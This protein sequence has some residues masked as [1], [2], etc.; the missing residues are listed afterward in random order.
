MTTQPKPLVS[1]RA[2]EAAAQIYANFRDHDFANWIRQGTNAGGDSNWAIQMMARFEAETLAS[3]SSEGEAVKQLEWCRTEIFSLCE[4]V[5][6]D[7]ILEKALEGSDH[8]RG[9]ARGQ[10]KTAKSIRNAMGEVL[11]VRI[12]EVKDAASTPSPSDVIE[13]CARVA[14]ER[15]TIERC[16]SVAKEMAQQ[17]ARSASDANY[18]RIRQDAA[19]KVETA[20]RALSKAKEGQH[21]G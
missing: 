21:H 13:K 11:R 17:W 5:E 9:Y 1:Q 7:P 15:T 8:E 12:A 18:D 14:E 10:M 2:R 19:L 4:S 6:D 16:A 3:L 20:I